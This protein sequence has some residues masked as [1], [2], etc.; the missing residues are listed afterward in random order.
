MN[1]HNDPI[2]PLLEIHL[3]DSKSTILKCFVQS[4][5][6]L[7]CSKSKNVNRLDFH[8]LMYKM[9]LYGV[10]RK[11]EILTYSRKLM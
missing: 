7:Y 1:N 10:I 6:C 2:K 4:C 3:N 11:N 5:L 9:E 8:Q